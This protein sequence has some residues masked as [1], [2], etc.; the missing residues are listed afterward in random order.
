MAKEY[1]ILINGK[2]RTTDKE[3]KVTN[4][5]DNSVVGVTWLGGEKELDEAAEGASL[6]FETLRGYP[7]YKRAEVI[8]KVVQGLIDRR[9]ELARTIT[10]EAGK[11]INDS[12]GEVKR[13]Q[14][15]F[16]IALEEA[17]RQDG[18]VLP[19]DI[20]PGAEGRTGIVKRFP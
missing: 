19:L 14:I 10:L 4:P 2:W 8:Q 7:S 17:R 13:A 20:M 11:P 16:Q 3:L 5:Y 15:T 9:E 12:R 18:T 6:A 1:R